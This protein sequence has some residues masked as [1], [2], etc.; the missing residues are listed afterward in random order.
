MVGYYLAYPTT[1]SITDTQ[2]TDEIF[3]PNMLKDHLPPDV[4]LCNLSPFRS[5][6]QITMQNEKIPATLEYLEVL[7]N[8]KQSQ[9][10]IYYYFSNKLDIKS[11]VGY[12]HYIGPE[13]AAKLSHSG[14]EFIVDCQI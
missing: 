6:Y 12:Y 1:T 13:N 3:Q 2:I 4:T 5:N 7:E 10:L 11:L 8:F 9:E 14:E